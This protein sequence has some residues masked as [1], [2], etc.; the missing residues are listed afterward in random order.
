MTLSKEGLKIGALGQMK[1]KEL[2]YFGMDRGL[3]IAFH[4][5][6]YFVH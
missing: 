1:G 4:N 2:G 6:P 5:Q 3:S